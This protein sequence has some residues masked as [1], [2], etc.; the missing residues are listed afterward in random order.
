[1]QDR[2]PIGFC[3]QMKDRQQYSLLKSSK[4]I[5]HVFIV[6][7]LRRMSTST[8]VFAVTHYSNPY[9]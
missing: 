3:F 9:A 4:E 2:A 7:M 5:C 6:D 1:M 8:T